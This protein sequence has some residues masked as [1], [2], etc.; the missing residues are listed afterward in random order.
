MIPVELVQWGGVAGGGFS[1]V[2][3]G[4]LRRAPGPFRSVAQD[5]VHAPDGVPQPTPDLDARSAL[6][7]RVVPVPGSGPWWCFSVQVCGG[8][9]GRTGVCQFLFAPADGTDAW[10]LWESCV[11]AVAGGDGLLPWGLA[12]TG[13]PADSEPLGGAADV[14]TLVRVLTGLV[15]G[16]DAVRVEGAEA[17]V[18]AAIAGA[19]RVLPHAV[20]RERVWTTF[21][22]AAP[23]N[24]RLPRV[25]GAW[26]AA[27]RGTATADRVDQ[28]LDRK[29]A[30][31]STVDD[32]YDDTAAAVRWLAARVREPAAVDRYRPLP[33]IGAL[34]SAVVEN[35]LWRLEPGQVWQALQR[36][37]ERVL[38]A[39]NEPQLA[40]WLLVNASRAVEWLCGTAVG[41][42]GDFA[43][44]VFR[45]LV[46]ENPDGLGLPTADPVWFD[47]SAEL[48]RRLCPTRDERVKLARSLTGDVR[49]L[50]PWFEELGL[51]PRDAD[52]ADLFPVTEAAVVEEVAALG[53]LGPRGER[54]LS[55]SAAPA[56]V[57]LRL[58]AAV[59]PL[60]AGVAVSWLGRVGAESERRQLF[61][62]VLGRQRFAGQ[63]SGWL[64][65]ALRSAQDGGVRDVV[66]SLGAGAFGPGE[67][68]S[69]ELSSLCV[70]VAAGSAEPASC[71]A[72]FLDVVRAAVGGSRREPAELDRW[73]AAEA[74]AR[75]AAEHWEREYRE[76][77]R[78]HRALLGRDGGRGAK[79][80]AEARERE[81]DAEER[82][83]RHAVDDGRRLLW[84]RNAGVVL[85]F[86]VFLTLLVGLA[87]AVQQMFHR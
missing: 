79:R 60:S 3:D 85:A 61:R 47:R 26:P 6:G 75:E 59:P 4:G 52:L 86:V 73:R 81:S 65:D 87:V 69:L 56:E 13:L 83:G 53:D 64:L 31:P 51:D 14:V 50:G 48:A 8:R 7:L 44:T 25:T 38:R 45:L 74:A 49:A 63:A 80:K 9:F 57:L 62:A 67:Q 78:D 10:R 18:A 36:G 29:L 77:H 76:L 40:S 82:T 70:E 34:V 84:Q 46:R 27:L 55:G 54:L 33:T 32:E 66:A 42:T 43:D 68:P 28:W 71:F 37:E 41:L 16:H 35:E 39:E 24:P 23:G 19:L 72:V 2:D 20:A 17:E 1:P 12:T 21:L 5:L 30:L 22:A 58:V 11:A 15:E